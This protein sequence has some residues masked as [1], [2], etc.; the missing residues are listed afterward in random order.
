MNRF[1]GKRTL[2]DDKIELAAQ[3]TLE[4]WKAIGQ[5]SEEE[6]REQSHVTDQE[7][8]MLA[9]AHVQAPAM[10]TTSTDVAEPPKTVIQREREKEK[11][12]SDAQASLEKLT[13]Q[14]LSLLES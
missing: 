3:R 12:K 10:A 2:E 8:E 9:D 4:G 1:Q 6:E 14:A 11:P 7:K 13:E 5:P